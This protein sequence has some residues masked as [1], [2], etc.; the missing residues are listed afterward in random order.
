M[1]IGLTRI[2]SKGQVVIPL[3]LRKKLALKDGETLAISAEGNI[4]S[5]KK[6]K[7]PFEDEL[8][9]LESV[10]N[11]WKEIE[12]GKYNKLKDKDF[13]KTVSKW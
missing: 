3:A 10:K 12:A 13:L 11:A 9:T 8:R 2:S 6:V 7:N 1:E 5:L 4:I